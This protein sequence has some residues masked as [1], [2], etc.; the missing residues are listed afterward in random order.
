MGAISNDLKAVSPILDNHLD[1][2]VKKHE[3]FDCTRCYLNHL[4]MMICLF[5]EKL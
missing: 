2:I 5:Q 3:A 4:I 1:D